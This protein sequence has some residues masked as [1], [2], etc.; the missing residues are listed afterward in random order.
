MEG[1]GKENLM[2]WGAVF[3]GWEGEGEGEAGKEM[4]GWERRGGREMEGKGKEVKGKGK[5][6]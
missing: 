6:S 5:G 3:L 4:D 1:E 2:G